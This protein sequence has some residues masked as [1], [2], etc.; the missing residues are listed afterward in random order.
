[1]VT[2]L[3]TDPSTGRPLKPIEAKVTIRQTYTQ[4]HLH[5]KTPESSGNFAASKIIKKGD[6]TYQIY[7]VFRNHPRITVQDR[8]RPHLGALMLEVIG[9]PVSP[10]ELIGQYWTDRGT[11]GEVRGARN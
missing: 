1:M 6:G 2:S 10:D 3:W 7:G 4:L 5:L 9:E 11:S 8:S